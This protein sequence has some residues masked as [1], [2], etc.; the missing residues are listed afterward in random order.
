[1]QTPTNISTKE[2][3][4]S[5]YKVLRVQADN[6]DQLHYLRN[7][8]ETESDLSSKINFWS[9]PDRLNSSIDV[10]IAP[11]I[12]NEMTTKFG[13]QN[14]SSKTLINDVGK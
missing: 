5:G 11:D 9:E 1:M 3:T 7:L 6:L 12:V 10:M 4:Y 8:S 14:I 13:K 2:M